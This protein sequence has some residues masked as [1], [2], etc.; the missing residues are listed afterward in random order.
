VKVTPL[1]SGAAK[2]LTA[3]TKESCIPWFRASVSFGRPLLLASAHAPADPAQ[4]DGCDPKV[5][6]D[7]FL[8]HLLEEFG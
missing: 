7:V 2:P 1:P 4:R 3:W 8:P 6:G 5:S